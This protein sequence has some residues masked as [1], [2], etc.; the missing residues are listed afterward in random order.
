MRLDDKKH[1]LSRTGTLISIA[2]LIAVTAVGYLL[3]RAQLTTAV[4][5]DRLTVLGQDY[6]D[7]AQQ[8]NQAVNRTAV[9]ELWVKEGAISVTVRTDQ[10]VIETIA[11][12][13]VPGGEIYVD[14]VVLEGRLWIRRVFDD[15]TPPEQGVVVNPKLITIDW[16]AHDGAHGKAA[17]RQLTEGRWAVTATGSGALGLARVGEAQAVDLIAP[18]AIH[19]YEQVESQADQQANGIGVGEI[20][21]HL[22]VR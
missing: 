22:L 17:Y 10:G 5:R 15:K 13:F 19:D 14:Y 2:M 11:T 20:L 16:D 7:L 12:P 21:K 3:L 8:Y 6:T 4:Y 9:T 18:P 1:M